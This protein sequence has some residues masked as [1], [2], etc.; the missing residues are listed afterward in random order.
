MSLNLNVN[1]AM[2][3]S[4]GILANGGMEG[5]EDGKEY[6]YTHTHT[7]TYILKLC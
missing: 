7:H 3:S 2:M 6:I 4:I 5:L 1:F